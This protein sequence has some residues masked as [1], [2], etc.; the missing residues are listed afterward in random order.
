MALVAVAG[1]VMARKAGNH[2]RTPMRDPVGMVAGRTRGMGDVSGM[3]LEVIFQERG[4][5]VPQLW[6]RRTS[7]S[8]VQSEEGR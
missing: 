6:E 4:P 5:C 2:T 7:M 3:E 8:S 1:M